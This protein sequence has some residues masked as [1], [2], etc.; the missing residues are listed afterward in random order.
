[1]STR[2][3]IRLIA[4]TPFI[5]DLISVWKKLHV[6]KWLFIYGNLRL[7]VCYVLV[8]FSLHV[9]ISSK[10]DFHVD[11]ERMTVKTREM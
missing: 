2:E 1:M 8:V 5:V 7:I 3:N 10:Y 4:R 6:M 11:A 9:F